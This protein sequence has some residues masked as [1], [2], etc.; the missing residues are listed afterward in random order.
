[1]L[2]E[3]RQGWGLGAQPLA[4]RRSRCAREGQVEE[5]EKSSR[6]IATGQRTA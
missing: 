6:P 5:E 4:S 2:D 3:Q 1:M